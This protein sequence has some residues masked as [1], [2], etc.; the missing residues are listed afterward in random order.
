MWGPGQQARLPL[1]ADRAAAP[2]A[3]ATVAA[4]ALKA[5]MKHHVAQS[6]A[7][8][9]EKVCPSAPQ[10]AW[11]R[12]ESDTFSHH[13]RALPRVPL[14]VALASRA[15]LTCECLIRA[16]PFAARARIRARSAVAF[17]Q[18]LQQSLTLGS[19]HRVPV[20]AKTFRSHISKRSVSST[21]EYRGSSRVHLAPHTH[22]ADCRHVCHRSAA[23]HLKCAYRTLSA[24]LRCTWQLS[25]GDARVLVL[26]RVLFGFGR[27]ACAERCGN[28]AASLPL[29]QLQRTGVPLFGLAM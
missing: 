16:G 5:S 10:L 19:H 2:E 18:V 13:R 1:R 7:E 24:F 28:C 27:C 14:Y 8:C 11:A 12:L 25:T 15:H 29:P 4:A 22:T 23:A 9:L 26:G 6:R 21:P 3:T 20:H 17:V